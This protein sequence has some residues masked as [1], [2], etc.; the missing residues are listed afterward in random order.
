MK[1]HQLRICLCPLI[2]FVNFVAG[3]TSNPDGRLAISGSVSVNGTPLSDNGEIVFSPIGSQAVKT[4]SSAI[5]SQGHFSLPATQGLVPGEYAVQF[6]ASR[7]T[8]KIDESDPAKPPIYE[9]II[10]EKYNSLSQEKITVAAK[11]TKFTFDLKV[12]ETDFTKK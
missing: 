1:I 10:P 3:C 12:E 5:I 7:N 4:P 9:L 2:L 11:A 6:H 8:G